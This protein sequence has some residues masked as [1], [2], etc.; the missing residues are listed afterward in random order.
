M[1]SEI[2]YMLHKVFWA[3]VLDGSKYHAKDSRG[4]GDTSNT[5]GLGI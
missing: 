1:K 4:S 5:H 2:E 3:I